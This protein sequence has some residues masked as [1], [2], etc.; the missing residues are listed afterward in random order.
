VGDGEQGGIAGRLSGREEELGRLVSFLDREGPALVLVSS[1][2]GMGKTTL[3]RAVQARASS[4]NWTLLPAPWHGAELVAGWRTTP[5]SF[6]LQARRLLGDVPELDDDP[7]PALAAVL[8]THAPLLL[9]L[10]IN[11]PTSAFAAWVA[12]E[13]MQD[14]RVQEAAV[15]VVAITASDSDE[16]LMSAGADAVIRLGPL[17]PEAVRAALSALP[18]LAPPLESAELDVYVQA[19]SASPAVITGLLRLLPYA[20]ATS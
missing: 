3:V 15:V 16:R 17:A 7:P 13:L 8:G 12:G 2:A 10:E 5:E 20:E 6:T 11:R 4:R 9:A 1:P 18:P 19:G 14:L